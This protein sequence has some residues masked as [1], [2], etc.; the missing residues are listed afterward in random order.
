MTDGSSEIRTAR[1]PGALHEG[2]AELL[3][4]LLPTVTEATLLAGLRRAQA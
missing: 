3:E 2:A 1:R 4:P